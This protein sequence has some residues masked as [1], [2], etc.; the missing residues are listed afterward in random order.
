MSAR[1]RATRAAEDAAPSQLTAEQLAVIAAS[2]AEL[3]CRIE[4]FRHRLSVLNAAV[5]ASSGSTSR[6]TR[7]SRSSTRSRSS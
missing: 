1:G 4:N 5:Q 2:L 6:S 3:A 7:D